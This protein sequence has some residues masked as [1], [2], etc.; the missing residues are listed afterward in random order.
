[1]AKPNGKR[2]LQG[3]QNIF[4][5]N[6]A[7]KRDIIAYATNN[8]YSAVNVLVTRKGIMQGGTSFALDEAHLNDSEVN[9]TIEPTLSTPLMFEIS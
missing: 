5:V 7:H 6:S 8:L 2:Q 9:T 3:I 4:A 1:M